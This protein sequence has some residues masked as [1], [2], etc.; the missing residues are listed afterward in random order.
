[1]KHHIQ[2]VLRQPRQK[3]NPWRHGIGHSPRRMANPMPPSKDDNNLWQ[4]RPSPRGRW[5]QPR[6]KPNP[7]RHGIGHFSIKN[8]KKW[9]IPCPKHSIKNYFNEPR[10]YWGRWVQPRRSLTPVLLRLSF[11]LSWNPVWVS[12]QGSILKRETQLLLPKK[13]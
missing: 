11:S 10:P 7:W 8:T 6:Q 4:M 1:M 9:P 5:W 2:G 13:G 3:P 12:K